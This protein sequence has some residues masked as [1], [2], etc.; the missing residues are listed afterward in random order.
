VRN[1]FGVKANVLGLIPGRVTYVID[2]KG[3]VVFMYESQLKAE[4]HIEES[5]NAINNSLD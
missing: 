1:L 5:I 3:K 4:R 2:K